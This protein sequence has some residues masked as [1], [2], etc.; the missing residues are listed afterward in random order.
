MNKSSR[1]SHNQKG[2]TMIELLAVIVILGI[3]SA[4]AIPLMGNVVQGAKDRAFVANALRMKEAASLNIRAQLEVIDQPSSP[5]KLSYADLITS[6]FL[7]EFKDPD[8]GE[9]MPDESPSYIEMANDSG[10]IIYRVFLEGKK[11]QIGTE[12][13]PLPTDT[14]TTESIKPVLAPTN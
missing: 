12:Q 14:L 1:L 8:T 10:N 5:K 4:I 6:G 9:M 11:R 13:Q 7:E 2:L 3:L